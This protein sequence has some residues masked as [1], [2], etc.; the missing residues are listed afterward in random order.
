MSAEHGNGGRRITFFER[1]GLV[2][3]VVDQGPLDGDIVVLLHG[4]PQ[5]A[6]SWDRLAPLLHASGYRTLAPDQ[7]GYSRGARPRGRFAYRLSDSPRMP[8][9]SSRQPGPGPAPA[10]CTS[11]G[12][13]GAPRSP[14]RSPPP[15]RTRWPP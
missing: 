8:S 2:F 7:R 11:S 14:G 9:P 12:T 1:K 13:T 6:S 15:G 10:R 3:D 5:R 4:F